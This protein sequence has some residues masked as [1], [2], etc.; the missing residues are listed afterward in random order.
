MLDVETTGLNPDKDEIIEI[1]AIK[2]VRGAELDRFHVL[3]RPE[4]RVGD[5]VVELTGITN[6]LL[7]SQGLT[8]NLP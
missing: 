7:E 5:K 4:K 6:D 2:V 1:A 3:V 8:S